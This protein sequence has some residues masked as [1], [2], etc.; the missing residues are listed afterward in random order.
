MKKTLLALIVGLAVLI[1]S[2]ALAAS[3]SCQAYGG[4][5]CP[6]SN[7]TTSTSAPAPTTGA[8]TTGTPTVAAGTTAATTASGTLP[9]TGLDLAALLVGASV[10]LGGGL[11]VRYLSRD[12]HN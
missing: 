6:T 12:Q 11:V 3:S 10:L 9:F 8:A 5:T 4:K 1:P 2:A 7:N